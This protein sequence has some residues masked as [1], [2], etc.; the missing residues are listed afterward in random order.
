MTH[1]IEADVVRLRLRVERHLLPRL[2]SPSAS[3]GDG[4]RRGCRLGAAAG[5]L[6]DG[7]VLD[8]GYV[9]GTGCNKY[10]AE[11]LIWQASKEEAKI[12]VF[13][14]SEHTPQAESQLMRK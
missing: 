4:V 8:L 3:A 6:G 9:H 14:C 1:P 5:E 13:D 11:S 7:V 2:A 12:T 10:I